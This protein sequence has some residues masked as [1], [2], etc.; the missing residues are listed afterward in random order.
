MMINLVYCRRNWS[1]SKKRNVILL[2][3]YIYLWLCDFLSFPLRYALRNPLRSL[4]LFLS[5]CILH[6]YIPCQKSKSSVSCAKCEGTRA[7]VLVGVDQD[8]LDSI[9]KWKHSSLADVQSV[10]QRLI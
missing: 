2:S 10:T 1:R 3:T 9:H 4:W 8:M 6:N 7:V 5:F